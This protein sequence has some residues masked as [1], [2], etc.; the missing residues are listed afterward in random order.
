MKNLKNC[1]VKHAAALVVAVLLLLPATVLAHCGSYDR[2]VIREA[3][4]ALKTNNVSLLY[5]WIAPADEAQIQML[6][7]KTYSL[8]NGDPEIYDLVETYFLETLVRLHRA[9]EG[10]AY[11]G[12]KPSGSVNPIVVM[13]DGALETGNIDGLPDKL[14]GHIAEVVR[15][16][17]DKVEM[18]SKQKELSPA[19][20]REYAHAYVDYVHTIEGI[21]SWIDDTAHAQGTACGTTRASGGGCCD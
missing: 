5:K 9:T 16:K 12:L 15:E 3:Q 18:L 19:K 7:D 21:H 14:T 10:A 4:K 13:S 11:T 6:F 20:G 17:F 2:P 8:R 1:F